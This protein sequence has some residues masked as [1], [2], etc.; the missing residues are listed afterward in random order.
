MHFV[1]FEDVS[2]FS[3]PITKLN[4]Y[5]PEKCRKLFPLQVFLQNSPSFEFVSCIFMIIRSGLDFSGALLATD[6]ASSLRQIREQM[7]WTRALII[8][9]L[10]K[11]KSR[12]VQSCHT[13]F[14]YQHGFDQRRLSRYAL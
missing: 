14:D 2:T 4:N 6:C 10:L 12:F 1:H 3:R 13:G 8:S 5:E 9:N 7:L 11:S